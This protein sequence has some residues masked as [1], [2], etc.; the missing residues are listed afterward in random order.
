MD[1]AEA[2]LREERS[3][4]EIIREELQAMRRQLMAMKTE[5]ENQKHESEAKLDATVSKKDVEIAN[6]KKVGQE[7]KDINTLTLVAF[8]DLE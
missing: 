3:D 6:L 2:E 8:H 7:V 1:R 5:M 4:H